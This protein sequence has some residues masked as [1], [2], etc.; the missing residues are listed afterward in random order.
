MRKIPPFEFEALGYRLRAFPRSIGAPVSRL[1]RWSE[2]TWGPFAAMAPPQRVFAVALGISIL[3]HSLLL[4]IHFQFP[5]VMRKFTDSQALEVV[6]VN[7]KSSS[8]P[9]KPDV[10]AQ[11]NLD[12][13]GNTDDNRRAK[14][15]LPVT[16]SVQA[17][18]DLQRATR[19]VQEL[20]AQQRQLLAQM[21]QAQTQSAPR[22]TTPTPNDPN[23]SG[24]DIASRSLALMRLEA[25]IA[26][27]VD[28]YNKRPRK[29][30]V[31]ARASEF[32]FA[33]YADEYRQKVERFGNL[34]Y[35]QEAR[36]RMYGSLQLA[37]SIRPDGSV[38]SIDILRSSGFPVLDRAAE[39]IVM[40][41]APYGE[42]PQDLRKD[43]DI[44][45]I[46][47][48]W[49]FVAGDRLFGE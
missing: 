39:R 11:A 23:I 38:E 22:A 32:R 45:V 26:R 42:F 13:G 3:F 36:G 8:R 47:R 1:F 19:R 16:P 35:P 44:L 33:R 12:G 31:G 20:E 43:T 9:L 37:V 27:N 21:Q 48:T 10:L 2:I 29:Q 25:E 6:L 14:T 46:T 28:E 18:D 40:M 7:S 17:G 30:F 24:V 5:D 4:S 49:R 41:A 15:P 34:N